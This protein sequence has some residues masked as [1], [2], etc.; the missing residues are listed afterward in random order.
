MSG[1][2]NLKMMATTLENIDR[3]E[4]RTKDYLQDFEE[5]NAAGPAL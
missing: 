3:I 2:N 4:D 1:V 5:E